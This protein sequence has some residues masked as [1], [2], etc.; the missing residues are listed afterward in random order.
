M[1]KFVNELNLT[2][3]LEFLRDLIAEKE[4]VNIATII[5]SGS[6]NLEPA[7]ALAVY[8]FV[9]GI[10]NGIT[11]ISY[12]VVT[13]LPTEGVAGRIYLINVSSDPERYQL[14]IYVDDEWRTIGEAELD[15]TGYWRKDEL[16]ALTETEVDT[17]LEDIFGS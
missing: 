12:E 2:Q 7:G 3:V 11:Q 13:E 16:T 14:S 1:V 17:I 9:T 15:L 6:T 4:N 8:E 5:N 10:F